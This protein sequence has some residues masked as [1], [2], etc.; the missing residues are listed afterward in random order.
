MLLRSDPPDL[1]D[2]APDQNVIEKYVTYFAYVSHDNHSN[3]NVIKTVKKDKAIP[4][5]GRGGP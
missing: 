3:T 1:R 2:G 4:V 5:T